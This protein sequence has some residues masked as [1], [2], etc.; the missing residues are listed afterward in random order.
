MKIKFS[1]ECLALIG[2]V[3]IVVGLAG[4]YYLLKWII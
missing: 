3:L 1:R 4:G 2:M